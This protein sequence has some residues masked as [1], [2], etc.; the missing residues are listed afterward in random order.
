MKLKLKLKYKNSR[1]ASI[2]TEK[3][4]SAMSTAGIRNA[5]SRK[6]V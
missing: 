4:E 5:D 3:D 6:E 1:S 2:I